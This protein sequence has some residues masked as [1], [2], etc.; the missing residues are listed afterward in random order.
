MFAIESPRSVELLRAA[1]GPEPR[2][3]VVIE[4]EAGC[5]RS[6]VSPSECAALARVAARQGFDV[7]GVFSYPGHSYAPGRSQR[8]RRG[9][10]ARA[11]R[12]GGCA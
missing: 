4:V 9:G 11:E 12:G 5:L 10:A 3:D 1:L 6:G 2:A 7:A 8:G